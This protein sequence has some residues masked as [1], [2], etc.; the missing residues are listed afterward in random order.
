ME[1]GTVEV[2]GET[3]EWEVDDEG[4]IKVAHSQHADWPAKVADVSGMRP[5]DLAKIL[6]AEMIRENGPE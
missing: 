6:A 5:R 3:F 2:D 1:T 4:S